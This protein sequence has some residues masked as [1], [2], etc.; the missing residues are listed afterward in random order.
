MHNLT[1]RRPQALFA[2][3]I[4]HCALL[5]LL[6]G[7]GSKARA[8]A[9]PDGPP[10]A[11]PV[12]PAHQIAIEQIAEAP[13]PEPEPTPEPEKPAPAVTT[14]KP[15]PQ[16]RAETP[17]PPT[18]PAAAAP[19]PQPE[20]PTVRAAPATGSATEG[21]VKAL[22]SQA[23]TDL[24]KRVD[25]QKLSTDGRAQYEQSKRFADEARQAMKERN[26]LLAL[27]LAEK[28]ANIAAE[29]IR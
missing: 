6:A 10:L 9:L 28:A 12:A 5:A 24:A 22:L 17:P 26:F 21:K 1:M 3:C 15:P 7:C 11:V 20:A 13:A 8:E 23:E 18:P 16:P 29:L 4:L 25:Y 14:R 27:T 19:Q 2:F